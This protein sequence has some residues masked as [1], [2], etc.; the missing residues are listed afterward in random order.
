MGARFVMTVCFGWRVGWR[1]T[2][3]ESAKWD[4]MNNVLGSKRTRVAGI[5]DYNQN[6]NQKENTSPSLANV[7]S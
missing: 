7:S 1:D 4:P 2:V 5:D 3:R 6:R